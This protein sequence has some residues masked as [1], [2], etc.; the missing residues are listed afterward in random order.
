MKVEGYNFVYVLSV[1][2]CFDKSQT[3]LCQIPVHFV[4]YLCDWKNKS[5]VH[6][7]PLKTHK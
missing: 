7:V 3:C 5:T 2:F 6:F 1:R 4:S